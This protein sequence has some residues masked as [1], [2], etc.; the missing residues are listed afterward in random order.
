MKKNK[1]IKFHK[2][3]GDDRGQLVAIEGNIDI[4]FDIKRVFY[5]YGTSLGVPRG[6]HAH[7]KTLQYLMCVSGS[8]KVTLD[9]G[10][11]KETYNLDG[12]NVGLL[13][14][15]LVWGTMH[16]F[17]ED[18]VLLVLASEHYEESDYIKDYTLFSKQ[19]AK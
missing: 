3:Q 1:I 15:E 9:T 16:D 13:Q 11:G 7:Y 5:I 18:C 17:S 14:K 4:P 19:V 12:Q 10:S 8:C 2:V 6:N